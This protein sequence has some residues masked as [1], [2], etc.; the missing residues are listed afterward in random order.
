MQASVDSFSSCSSFCL[1]FRPATSRALR[2]QMQSCCLMSSS[3]QRISTS[4]HKCSSP[5]WSP[6]LRTWS[7]SAESDC[8]YIPLCFTKAWW[9]FFCTP[10]RTA[11]SHSCYFAHRTLQKGSKSSSKPSSEDAA[12][13]A[14]LLQQTRSALEQLQSEVSLHSSEAEWVNTQSEFALKSQL[15]LQIINICKIPFFNWKKIRKWDC[16]YF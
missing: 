2:E 13:V 15:D 1:L 16:Y 4:S 7:T 14:M 5:H 12:D 10:A 9:I 8:D 11:P 6:G 3:V